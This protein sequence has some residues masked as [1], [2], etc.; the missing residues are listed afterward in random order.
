MEG[1]HPSSGPGPAVRHDVQMDW[2]RFRLEAAADLWDDAGALVRVPYDVKR[3]RASY[4]A[5]DGTRYDPPPELEIHHRDETLSGLADVEALAF[6]RWG[7]LLGAR[8]RLELAGGLT[9]PTGRTERDPFRYA[10]A[11]L[12]HRHYQFGT[13][14]VDPLLEIAYRGPLAWAGLPDLAATLSLGGRFPFYENPKGYRGAVQLSFTP[15]LEATV[16]SGLSVGIHFAGLWNSREYWEGHRAPNSGR[17][18]GGVLGTLLLD[19]GRGISASASVWRGVYD[20]LHT[21]DAQWRQDWVVSAGVSLVLPGALA[22]N[23]AGG[24][25]SGSARA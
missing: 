2:V 20:E 18:A 1:G 4:R 16:L 12:R 5:L 22:G 6:G 17:S 3:Q 23:E 24:P 7:D 8:D 14:T 15:G 10:A 25:L 13:G 19:L 21:D 11:G 9:F